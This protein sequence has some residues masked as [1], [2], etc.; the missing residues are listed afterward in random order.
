M[1]QKAY[2]GYGANLGEPRN[3][4]QVSVRS[5]EK[6][7]ETAVSAVSSLYR[8]KPLGTTTP[9]PDYYNAVIELETGLSADKLM[10]AMHKIE[11]A[12]GRI[13]PAPV[14]SARTLDLD[15]LLYG[16]MATED[17][18]LTLPHPRIQERAFVLYPLLELAPDIEIPGLGRAADLLSRVS[19]QDIERV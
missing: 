7:P 2:L 3:M 9:Q 17:D 6:L 5:L 10:E 19:G 12:N 14:N 8:S 4:I 1:K 16:K 11:S 15:L 13:R 18:S